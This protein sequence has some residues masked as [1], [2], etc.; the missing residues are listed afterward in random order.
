MAEFF[1]HSIAASDLTGD[2]YD[3]VLVGA[4]MYTTLGSP[5]KVEQG[6]LYVFF[7]SEVCNL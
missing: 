4:P 2:G 3:E 7:N 1:G 5:N 6:R